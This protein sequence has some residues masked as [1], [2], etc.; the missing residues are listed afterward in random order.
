MNKTFRELRK[1]DKLYVWRFTSRCLKIGEI[2]DIWPRINPNFPSTTTRSYYVNYTIL[3]KGW[4][5][6]EIP[7]AL[8][9]KDVYYIDS[10]LYL[11]VISTSIDNLLK[12]ISEND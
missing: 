7:F 10:D 8:L 9:E 12:Y 3:G 1:G 11:E 5:T 6:I 2:I 4:E